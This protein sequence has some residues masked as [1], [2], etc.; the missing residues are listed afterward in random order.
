ML[1]GGFSVSNN[2]FIPGTH[3]DCQTIVSVVIPFQTARAIGIKPLLIDHYVLVLSGGSVS[4]G[5]FRSGN[6]PQLLN[7]Y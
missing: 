1:S 6:P 2:P 5:P 4:N 7:D 3:L